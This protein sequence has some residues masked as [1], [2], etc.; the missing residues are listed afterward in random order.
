ML[1]IGTLGGYSTIW[2]ARA[3]PRG[4]RI[5]SLEYNPKHAEVARK[6]LQNAGL[7]KRVDM[8]VGR[9]LDSLPVLAKS[10]ARGRSI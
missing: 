3:L 2:M 9:A 5:V 4:G 10:R 1:E 8:R 7:L 6:N